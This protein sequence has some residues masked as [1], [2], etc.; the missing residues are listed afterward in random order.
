MDEHL[1]PAGAVVVGYDGSPASEAALAWACAEAKSWHRPLHLVHHLTRPDG[2]V[3][4]LDVMGDGD[5]VVTLGLQHAQR[6]APDVA[7]TSQTVVGA[8]AAWLVELSARAGLV[9]VAAHGHHVLRS[10]LDSGAAPQIAPRSHCP[11][12]VVHEDGDEVPARHGQAA[13]QRLAR[14]TVGIDES[15]SCSSAVEFAFARASRLGLGLTA[16]AAWQPDLRATG[17]RDTSGLGWERERAD[18]E[19][20]LVSEQLAGWSQRYPD[21][22]V[23]IV[24][25]RGDPVDVLAREADRSELLVL[26][27]RGRGGLAGLFLGSVSLR[28]P[29]AAHRPVAIVPPAPE[30]ATWA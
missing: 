10:L 14:V 3:L 11:V 23:E 21:V 7:M 16:V 28:V 26:G 8:A 9:V 27:T 1:M 24:L 25:A 20:C 2:V 12:V 4:A 19:R 22:D 13:R 5:D 17:P 29:P 15:G 30:R 18:G 6:Q